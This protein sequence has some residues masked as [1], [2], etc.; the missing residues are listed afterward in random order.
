GAIYDKNLNVIHAIVDNMKDL[1]KINGSKYVQSNIGDNYKNIKKL[2]DEGRYV[3]FSGTPCQVSGLNSFLGKEY[4]KLYT[5]DIVCHGV[6]SPKV[7]DKYKNNLENKFSSKLVKINF[8][9]K[10]SGWQGYSFSAEFENG[11]KYIQNSK[12]NEYMKIFIGDIDLRESCPT[13]KFAK[14]PR[15]CDFTLGDFWGVDNCYP[16]LNQDNSGTSLV[17]VHTE[18]GKTLLEG[19][20]IYIKECDLDIAIKGNPS[21]LTHKSAHKCRNEFLNEIDEY[22]IEELAIKYFPKPN[23]VKRIIKKFLKIIK[24]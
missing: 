11:K 16:E 5:C 21:I 4:D 17:L 19:S 15:N 9:D 3:L 14:L 24:K 12:E 8:R 22:T 6:P 10:I 20:D 1:K 23:F 13:C 7:F 18:K 2:L